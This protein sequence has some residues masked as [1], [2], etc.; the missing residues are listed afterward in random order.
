M[1]KRAIT[2]AVLLVVLLTAAPLATVSAG[3]ESHTPE[4][5]LVA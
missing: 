3:S 5:E 1:M 2:I 4:G